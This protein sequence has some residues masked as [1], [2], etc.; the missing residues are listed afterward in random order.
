MARSG[1]S[2]AHYT[3]LSAAHYTGLLAVH[4]E[5]MDLLEAGRIADWLAHNNHEVPL[6]ASEKSLD[7]V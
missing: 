7:H 6:H 4:V 3:G 2:A 5:H 1:L